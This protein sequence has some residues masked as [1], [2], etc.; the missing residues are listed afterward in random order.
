MS[1]LLIVA[2]HAIYDRSKTLNS[3]FDN[4]RKQKGVASDPVVLPPECYW[5]GFEPD[6]F[7][8]DAVSQM[9]KVVEQHVKAGCSLV[10]DD[11]KYDC[12]A[13]SGGRTRKE[14]HDKYDGITFGK[15]GIENSEGS[16]M[17]QFA[18]DEN[19]LPDRYFA[20]ECATDS[21]TNVLYSILGYHK[22]TG[23]DWPD[24]IGVVSMPH[25]STRFHLMA[26][27]LGYTG[28]HF[29]FHGVGSIPDLESNAYREIKNMMALIDLNN[30]SV[31]RD[32][33]LR[34][35][36][37]KKKRKGREH[38]LLSDPKKHYGGH[39]DR[40]L[41]LDLWEN[42]GVGQAEWKLCETKW[43]WKKK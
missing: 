10:T 9:V 35:D 28:E 38:K 31:I 1:R 16:G 27:G 39:P 5:H 21:F 29:Q 36:D 26:L 11:K 42:T 23:G 40:E 30:E 19:C 25:K 22:L 14:L 3:Y 18:S 37:F 20:E 13:F 6:K 34:D 33:L 12:V 4:L 15:Q 43:P 24:E 17:V 2:G 41:A 7:K 8:G 32:P